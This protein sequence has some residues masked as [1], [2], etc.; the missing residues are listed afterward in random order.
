VSFGAPQ[1][2]VRPPLDARPPSSLSPPRGTIRWKAVTGTRSG[3]LTAPEWTDS[4]PVWT[5]Q[6]HL[7]FS[8]SPIGPSPRKDLIRVRISDGTVTS[9]GVPV[10]LPARMPDGQVAGI[11]QDK[12]G[13]SRLIVVDPSRKG[14]QTVTKIRMGYPY[15]GMT[16]SAFC[17]D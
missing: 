8:V 11:L 2:E 10:V 6:D 17:P 7:V 3:K 16:I 9:L 12:P 14:Y 5:D 13:D 4:P 15:R 1:V